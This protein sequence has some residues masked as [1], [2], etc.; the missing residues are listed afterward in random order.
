M[1]ADGKVD[2]NDVSIVAKALGS[3]AGQLNWNPAADLNGDNKVDVLDCSIV[4]ANFG[5]DYS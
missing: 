3:C 5:N 2:I 4:C 1:N